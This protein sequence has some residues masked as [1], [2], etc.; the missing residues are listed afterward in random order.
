MV[1]RNVVVNILVH[2]KPV[3][4]PVSNIAF[5]KIFLVLTENQR[6]DSGHRQIVNS[7]AGSIPASRVII[8]FLF[9]F[10]FL[11]TFPSLRSHV[12]DDGS[13]WAIHVYAEYMQHSVV[14]I[15]CILMGLPD[16][17]KNSFP[18]SLA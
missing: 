6:F 1:A 16:V 13:G 17:T 5:Q 15:G 14:G 11:D 4:I 3:P 2:D 18:T 8:F 9:F 10:S 12:V 7:S